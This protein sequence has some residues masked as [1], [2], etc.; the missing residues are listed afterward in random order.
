MKEL[1]AVEK[2]QIRINFAS[3]SWLLLQILSI[4]I[5]QQQNFSKLQ[6]T[7]NVQN[8]PLISKLNRFLSPIMKDCSI[9]KKSLQ[10]DTITS[11]IFLKQFDYLIAITLQTFS[12]VTVRTFQWPYKTF[13][14]L[15]KVSR[16]IFRKYRI[17][18]K[19]NVTKLHSTLAVANLLAHN[20]IRQIC[21]CSQLKFFWQSYTFG[22]TSILLAMVPTTAIF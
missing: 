10:S 22:V 3:R 20:N 19:I 9:I 5:L 11:L 8:F 1:F 21:Y 18:S 16:I 12:Y 6:Q 4:K 7:I 2:T 14:D 13:N 15:I 17:A